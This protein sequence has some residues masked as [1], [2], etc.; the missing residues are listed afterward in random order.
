LVYFIIGIVLVTLA[1]VAYVCTVYKHYESED[2]YWFI[3]SF[4]WHTPALLSAVFLLESVTDI[5][6]VKE[7]FFDKCFQFITCKDCTNSIRYTCVPTN[8]T[9]DQI[10]IV[11]GSELV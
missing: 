6:L 8:D 4:F 1:F 2:D 7:S 9:I 11:N 3:H 10:E 5:N